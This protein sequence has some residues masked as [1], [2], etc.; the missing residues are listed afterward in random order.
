MWTRLVL[1][2]GV[3]SNVRSQCHTEDGVRDGDGYWFCLSLHWRYETYLIPSASAENPG[4]EPY[5]LEC[6]HMEGVP[7]LSSSKMTTHGPPCMLNKKL[8]STTHWAHIS[9]GK[10]P[11]AN[12]WRQM[13]SEDTRIGSTKVHPSHRLNAGGDSLHEHPPLAAASW[14]PFQ[15]LDD[16]P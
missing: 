15:M 7:E 3:S 4:A 9:L 2:T 6:S 10:T 16:P 8:H 1:E 11:K 14:T 13:P 12:L 5:L